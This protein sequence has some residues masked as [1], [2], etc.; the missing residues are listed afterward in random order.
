MNQVPTAGC[1]M[2]PFCVPDE[3]F[4]LVSS[5]IAAIEVLNRCPCLVMRIGEMDPLLKIDP[6]MIVSGQHPLGE[7]DRG[8]A[9]GVTHL[10]PRMWLSACGRKA[11]NRQEGKREDTDSPR[12][13]HS[14]MTFHTC[15]LTLTVKRSVPS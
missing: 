14:S 2:G 11:E 5:F 9:N 13:S 4:E 3:D 1:A 7:V 12:F 10:P 8:L 15:E 6:G